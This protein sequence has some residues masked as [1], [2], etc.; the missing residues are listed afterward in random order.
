MVFIQEVSV[1]LCLTQEGPFLSGRQ[2]LCWLTQSGLCF[3]TCV[4]V[5]QELSA[6]SD[7]TLGMSAP[8]KRCWSLSRFFLYN[9]GIDAESALDKRRVSLF[10]NITPSSSKG[11]LRKR[12]V[13]LVPNIV[14]AVKRFCCSSQKT[15]CLIITF[16]VVLVSLQLKHKGCCG[17]SAKQDVQPQQ[18]SIL[19]QWCTASDLIGSEGLR[20]EHL[21]SWSTRIYYHSHICQC[22]WATTSAALLNEADRFNSIQDLTTPSFFSFWEK[23]LTRETYIQATWINHLKE[24]S[25]GSSCLSSLPKVICCSLSRCVPSTVPDAWVWVLDERHGHAQCVDS[26]LRT[27]LKFRC[28][29]LLHP[30]QAI[31]VCEN[32]KAKLTVKFSF[33]NVFVTFHF[34]EMYLYS[35]ITKLSNE[36]LTVHKAFKIIWL[37]KDDI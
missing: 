36:N 10:V 32:G 27:V 21:N 24:I 15:F 23:Q 2:P 26:V 16:Q 37:Q 20:G 11:S 18:P 12:G 34:L 29:E 13:Y 8:A 4:N 31:L 19:Q 9:L 33:V 28:L 14:G 7:F 30:S 22:Q 17:T 1:N 35:Q 6:L 25:L 3:D 5:W